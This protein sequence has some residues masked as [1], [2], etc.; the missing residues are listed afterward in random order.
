MIFYRCFCK[1]LHTLP[2]LLLCCTVP[3]VKAF[4]ESPIFSDSHDGVADQGTEKKYI[5]RDIDID[6]REIFDD[7]DLGSFYRTANSLKINTRKEIIKR[8]LLLRQGHPFTQFDLEE[9]ERVLRSLRYIRAVKITP[10][11]EGD[12]VDIKVSVQDTWT[13]IP[14]LSFSAGSGST[15][16]KAIGLTESNLAGFGKRIELLYRDKDGRE[17]IESVWQDDRVMGTHNRMLL[18]YFDRSDGYRYITSIGKPY[19]NLDSKRSWG[20]DFDV[21][22]GVGRLYDA[23]DERFIFGQERLDLDLYYSFSKRITEDVINRFYTGYELNNYKFREATLKDF[24]DAD[25]NPDSVLM[26]PSLIPTNRKF[27]Y[28]YLSY[29]RIEADFISHSYVDRFDRVQDF[30]LGNV[31]TAKLGYAPTDFGSSSDAIIF[32]FNDSDGFNISDRSF[33]RGE[34]GTAGRI[35]K[36]ELLNG[37]LRGEIKFVY[38]LGPRFLGEQFIG[39]H[40]IVAS[41]NINYGYELDGERE[42]YVGGATGIRGYDSRTFYGDKSFFVNVEDRFHLV[43]DI[44]KLVSVGGAFFVDIGGATTD[45]LGDLLVD[46]LYGDFGVGLRLAFPRS[47]G[48]RVLRLDLAVPFRDGPDGTNGYE[49]RFVIEGGSL[50]ESLLQSERVGPSQVN[51]NAGFSD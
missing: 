13:L 33:L 25:I 11:Y 10:V 35:E 48:G 3:S 41:S 28:P 8:E 12:F 42:F 40:T 24:D 18:G 7:P 29:S 39:N 20:V 22:D 36:G 37:L 17:S 2:F 46:E 30:N 34:V 44:L 23:G 26:D 6:I 27:S 49:V 31:F 51:V 15:D 47:T 16:E 50:F 43:D 14:Y 21:M 4:A 19:R 1:I 32:S 9:S 45:S 38:L 5:I